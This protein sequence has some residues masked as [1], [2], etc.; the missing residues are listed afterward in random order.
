MEALQ[1][2]IE[3]I[4]RSE[5]ELRGLLVSAADQGDY[6][7]VRLLADWAKQ[8]R[9]LIHGSAGNEAPKASVEAAGAGQMDLNL[10]SGNYQ[11]VPPKPSVRIKRVPNKRSQRES[12]RQKARR[13][14]AGAGEYPKFFRDREEL[15]KV[16]WSKRER[17][18]YQHKAPK[19]VLFL[20]VEALKRIGQNGDR[21]SME[22]VL[23]LHDPLND[24]DVPSYQ[25]YLSLAWL[26]VEEIIV[27]H[28][29]QGYALPKDTDIAA[30]A[31]ARWRQL[32]GQ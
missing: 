18:I 3:A 32:A 26:R 11:I 25:A 17:A 13:R 5:G 30:M 15:V 23:P 6:D 24:S 14:A 1:Q 19:R 4:R 7:S 8:L 22:Q 20:L 28:G 9:E 12:T 21:F 29:R 16:G 2:A 10:R 27:Q 31:E